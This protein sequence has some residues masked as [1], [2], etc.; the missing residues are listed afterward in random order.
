MNNAS[1]YVIRHQP[2]PSRD[3]H[4]NIGVFVL[5][6]DGIPYVRLATNIRKIRALDPSADL[7]AA[8]EQEDGIPRFLSRLGVRGVDAVKA[9]RM[10]GSW[11]LSEHPGHFEYSNEQDFE[12]GV[13]WAIAETCEPRA[14][15]RSE[16][17]EL[18]SRLF[19]DLK[20]TFSRY[21]WMGS[22]ATDIEKHLIVSRYPLNP[23]EHVRAEFALKNGVLHVIET[24]DFRRG[25]AS[26]RHR[27]AMQKA[28]VFSIAQLTDKNAFR[29]VIIAASNSPDARPSLRLLEH[30]AR[31]YAYE[32]TADMQDLFSHLG[33]ATGK[34]ALEIPLAAR[35]D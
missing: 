20:N 8:R 11:K 3:E 23:E 34:P 1:F 26:E 15:R 16:P 2:Y 27:Q 28:T 18:P 35:A 5:R 25:E 7:S 12:R 21:G 4:V 17:R 10:F 30:F 9:F 6:A 13:Q 32:S 33:N 22:T 29:G 19:V 24:V 14:G 31:V